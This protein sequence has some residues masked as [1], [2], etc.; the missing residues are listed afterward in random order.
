MHDKD[1]NNSLHL[2][3][4]NRYS[5]PLRIIRKCSFHF[6]GLFIDLRFNLAPSLGV[7]SLTLRGRVDL[8]LQGDG[9]PGLCLY[10]QAVGRCCWED[11][12]AV[13]TWGK[14]KCLG[15][16]LWVS[17]SWAE[18][19]CSCHWA[20]KWFSPKQGQPP[21]VEQ[22]QGTT[23]IL[24]RMF[25][26]SVVLWVNQILLLNRGRVTYKG[27]FEKETKSWW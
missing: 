24:E 23:S 4:G 2:F 17:L 25:S 10:I 26:F 18:V 22:L 6:H 5:N 3:S 21:V 12:L 8:A 13:Q 1:P 20:W 16:L 27:K 11:F 15:V 7:I 19:A 14:T 9:I